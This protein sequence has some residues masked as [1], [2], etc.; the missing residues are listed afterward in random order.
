MEEK[1]MKKNKIWINKKNGKEYMV[2]REGIDC[3]NERDGLKV[4]IYLALGVEDK[5]FVREKNEFLEK[6]TEAEDK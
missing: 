5:I 6:F 1:L 4:V 2:L 3:T